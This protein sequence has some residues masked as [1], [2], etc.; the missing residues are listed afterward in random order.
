M[1]Q[2][3]KLSPIILLD[4]LLFL[5]QTQRK[6]TGD[7]RTGAEEWG[8]TDDR[9]ITSTVRAGEDVRKGKAEEWGATDDRGITSTVREGE[10]VRKGK[11][12]EEGATDDRS[13]QGR[14]QLWF[15]ET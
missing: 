1:N 9:G 6:G 12:E 7:I 10:D 3:Q 4:L 11:A 8:A 15:K 5:N 13:N 2:L 14:K